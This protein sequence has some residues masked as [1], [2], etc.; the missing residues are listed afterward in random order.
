MMPQSSGSTHQITS[1]IAYDLMQDHMDT[2]L[3]LLDKP[4]EREAVLERVGTKV[5]DRLL[6]HGLIV[7]QAGSLH[8]V[9]DIYH[10]LRQ[11]GMMTF[12]ERYVLPGL[13]AGAQDDGFAQLE[14]RHLTLTPEAMRQLRAGRVQTLFA[15][16]AEISDQPAVGVVS[17]LSILVVGTSHM[18]SEDM[19]AS[20][21][22]MR[23]L[24]HAS[25]QRADASH[26]DIAILSQLDML[27]DSARYG[28][29]LTAMNEFFED[30]S[31]EH[32]DS[33]DEANYH[34]TIASH[35]RHASAD[36]AG[37]SLRHLC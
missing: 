16:I 14:N 19:D 28:A 15:R 22:A 21:R 18:V 20:D 31:G 9:S 10:Q 3:T 13:T 12:L 33:L 7:E 29:T 35:W 24:Q 2:I 6:K 4:L 11:E 23:Y 34:L 37:Q 27:A 36:T 32:T 1:E 5:V 8:A 30:F 25:L 17:R 26:R